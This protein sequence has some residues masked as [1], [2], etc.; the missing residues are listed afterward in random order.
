MPRMHAYTY[1][2][3]YLKLRSTLH[4]ALPL[5]IFV[6]SI[7]KL[8]VVKLRVRIE[9]TVSTFTIFLR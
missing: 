6:C 5:L 9:V 7:L 8:M 4:V 3:R 1:I 2:K